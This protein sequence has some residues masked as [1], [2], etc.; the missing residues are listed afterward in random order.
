MPLT[1]RKISRRRWIVALTVLAFGMR[2]FVP[3]GYMLAAHASTGTLLVLCD[4]WSSTAGHDHGAMHHASGHGGPAHHGGPS[5]S[6]HPT[7]CPFSANPA[8]GPVSVPTVPLQVAQVTPPP[9][10]AAAQVTSF[11]VTYRAQSP[12]GP[13][14]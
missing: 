7:Q 3:S 11:A 9:P 8:P 4:G 14:R 12:R 2:A 1:L 6:T 5:S 10:L 13:P